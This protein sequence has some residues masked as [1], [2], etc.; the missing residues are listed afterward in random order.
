MFAAALS[1][2][3]TIGEQAAANTAVAIALARAL[4]SRGVLAEHIDQLA[5]PRRGGAADRR[6]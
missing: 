5:Q 4:P 1:K 2:P 6:P 3:E